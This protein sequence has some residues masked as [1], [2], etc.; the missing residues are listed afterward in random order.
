[1]G[2]CSKIQRDELFFSLGKKSLVKTI[3]PEN[4]TNT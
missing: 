4:G 3:K 2:N 1:M